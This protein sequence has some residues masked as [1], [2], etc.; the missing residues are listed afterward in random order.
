MSLK[1]WK[2]VEHSWSDTSI[3]DENG[4]IVCTKSI[5]SEATE[6]TQEDLELEVMINFALIASAPEMYAMLVRISRTY[7]K[8]TQTYIEL[9]EL[10]KKAFPQ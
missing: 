10:I 9:Q 6:E 4:N 3:E 7:D 1:K 5:E 2:I 8:G